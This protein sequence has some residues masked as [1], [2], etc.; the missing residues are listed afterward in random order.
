MTGRA[1]LVTGASSGIG[2][3]TAELLAADGHRVV[4]AARR[5]DDIKGLDGVLP[6][7]LD[8][9]DQ[10]GIEAAHREAADLIGSIDVL[11]NCAGYGEFG[12]VEDTTIDEARRQLEVNVL[13]AMALVQHVLPAMREARSGRIV[14][15]SSIAGE[16]AAPL[17]GWYHAS[18]FA[19]EALSDSLRGEVRPFGIEVAVV[20]PTYVD[21][22]WH[23][24][25]MGR[26]R[27]TSE[28]GAYAS[29]VQAMA[30]HFASAGMRKQMCTVDQV[31]EVVAT[32]ALTP[33]PRTRYRV[34]RGANLAVALATVL[35]DRWF[36]AAT[37]KQFGYR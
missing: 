18:K 21:T 6:V 25:A 20:Q 3:R 30:G 4:G 12:A 7:A 11:I 5:T 36:D 2:A 16:F 22:G 10:A 37:R 33:R 9:T 27:E 14:N 15:V 35:P 26:L 13:G 19:L 34:G 32:A 23:H 1:I 28:H 31:A 8:L 24:E 17:G 29:M